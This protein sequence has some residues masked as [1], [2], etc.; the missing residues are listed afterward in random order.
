MQ[1]PINVL[2]NVL[3]RIPVVHKLVR[4]LPKRTTDDDRKILLSRM[5][6]GGVCAEIGVWKGAFSERIVADTR[7]E[8]LYLVDPWAFQPQFP[9][10]IYGGKSARN[11]DDM[12]EID[13]GVRRRFE[14]VEAVRIHRKTF[15]DFAGSIPQSHLD[16]I[17]IDGDHSENA[18]REDLALAWDLVKSGGCVAGDDY[19]WRDADGSRPV[20]AA[21]DDFC[22][23][24]NVARTLIGSQYVIWKP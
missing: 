1:A 8:V 13:Q 9:A 15:R 3:I 16:W 14:G 6:P 2:R 10:R 11:Q 24:K 23:H 7:P 18:V 19:G 20:K 12:D 4:Y 21:V 17:Y 22:R 5:R